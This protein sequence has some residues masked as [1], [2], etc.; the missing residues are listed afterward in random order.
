[1]RGARGPRGATVTVGRSAFGLRAA[2]H[3]PWLPSGKSFLRGPRLGQAAISG[4]DG[5]RPL[6]SSTSTFL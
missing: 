6:S 2:W 4:W 3:L 1:M 5:P